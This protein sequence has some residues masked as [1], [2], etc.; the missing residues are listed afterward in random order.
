VVVAQALQL[1]V[2]TKLTAPKALDSWV[3]RARLYERLDGA[4][5]ARLT[6]VVA[7]A[8]FGKSTL[9]AQ[10]LVHQPA[11]RTP[12]PERV[13]WLTLD[14]HDQ[15][16]LR[17]LTYVLGALERVAPRCFPATH[18]LL[19][20]NEPPLYVIIQT[21]LAELGAL[22]EA[23]TLVLD[24]YHQ[25][26][27]KA[28]HQSVAYML[29]HL[30]AT[31]HLVMV[32]RINPPLPLAR[33]RAEGQV[34]ELR[35]ADLR[36]SVEETAAVLERLS[37]SRPSDAV[38]T[39]LHEQT[40]GW[41]IAVQLAGLGRANAHPADSAGRLATRQ[42][43]EYLA[44]EVLDQQPE[45]VQRALLLLAVPERFCAD[46]GATLLD[47]PTDHFSAEN[48]LEELLR[49]NLL[50]IPL[51]ND[52]R[53]Y[54][55]HHL[56]RDLLLRRLH[57]TVGAAG[58]RTL[59]VRAARWLA[60]EGLAEEAVRL[61]LAA[62]DE[63]SAAD[64]VERLLLPELG[65]DVASTPPGHW[66][67]M[68]PDNLIARRPALALIKARL[69]VFSMDTKGFEASL[70]RVDE[71]LASPASPNEAPPWPSFRADLTAL[72]GI[73]CFYRG[74][75]AEASD[76]M[77]A[78]LAR[79]PSQALA[80]QV[81]LL[82]A[83]SYVG[84]GEYAEGV[85]LVTDGL[86]EVVELLGDQYVLYQQ[87]CLASMHQIAGEHPA[88]RQAAQRLYDEVLRRKHSG[89]WAGYAARHLGLV[90]YE[91][92]E[93][94]E[95]ARHY[96]MLVGNKYKVSYPAYMGGVIGMAF[97]SAAQ[98][99]FIEAGAFVQE[100]LA[101]AEEA[102][103]VFL[104]N[105]ALGC[106]TR[107]ALARGDQRAALESALAI[108]P[109][110]HLGLSMALETPRLSQ[111]WAL[112]RAGHEH[113]ARAEMLLA[114]CRSE[115]ETLH[116]TRLLVAVLAL[117]GLLH[118]ARDSHTAALDTLERAVLLAAPRGFMRTFLDFGPAMIELLHTL[119]ARDVAP[120]Y[121]ARILN[122]AK[123]RPGLPVLVAPANTRTPTYA[124]L[125]QREAEVLGL[126]AER[127]SN[128]EIAEK[129]VVTVNTVRKHTSTIYDKLGVTSRREAV[130][131]ASAL[132][133]LPNR[134]S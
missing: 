25:I 57:L 76:L 128:Q 47:T 26:V 21:L 111:V 38:V 10:W 50:L 5:Q 91:S 71:L 18:E 126:L 8:G 16:G 35:A 106:A 82:L 110:M 103:G 6:L 122:T 113:L 81:A 118:A 100:A 85:R 79:R 102:G 34:V 75:P 107:V 17:F 19:A 37:G 46:L 61:F 23:L 36:F 30:P 67:P 121:L 133:L 43:A 69:A 99:A 40:E 116:N 130:A 24:D 3:P 55:F 41:A 52:G 114:G 14:E 54:R 74:Q 112:I 124:M 28:V 95:A 4:P 62:G 44:D 2:P 56:F 60:S 13:A 89:V 87:S 134:Q 29:R 84:N 66:L 58:V 68:L 97:V 49:A 15:D 48:L 127:W 64:L 51:D 109:D 22:P 42:L 129:L 93:L 131:T 20:G 132:G 101:F 72:H 31:C 77:R 73:R 94:A 9:V 53:W 59:R 86:P 96:G 39:T 105:Q 125:T 92:S 63:D 12:T 115:I 33:L 70:A 78:A 1:L 119:A 11:G 108:G 7:P 120:A 83:L 90:A 123:A 45:A 98:G 80:V 88:Q 104:R 117:E 32:S 27:S 65:K